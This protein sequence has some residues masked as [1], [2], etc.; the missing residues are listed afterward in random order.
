MRKTVLVTG[1]AGFIGSH[2]ADKLLAAGYKVAILDSLLTGRIGNVP[3]EASFYQSDIR[4]NNLED[5]FRLISPDY[6]LHQAAVANVRESLEEP[7]LYANVNL[8]GSLNLLQCCHK[9]A[10]KK[11]VYASTGGAVYGE[12]KNLPI[13]E[14]H[15]IQPLDPYGASKHHV[16]H[17]LHILWENYGLKFTTLR[18]SNVYGPRQD[19]NGEAGVVA[20]FSRSMLQGKNVTINGNG[21]Q[22]RDFVYVED[23]A[24]AN[25]L[26]LTNGNC[27]EYNLGTGTATSVN[28]LFEML[29]ELTEYRK[30]PLHAPPK[31]G[32]VLKTSLNSRAALDDLN[33]IAEVSLEKGLRQTLESFK[34]PH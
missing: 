16:E 31:Q 34:Y 18:Y 29:R 33:W 11:I 13:E 7:V 25:L 22:K 9:Y 23:I 32:E 24:R 28:Q 10:V 21:N 15:S 12:P 5:V 3:S 2:I 8:V 30:E 14:S 4:D 17:H 26:A 1:G 19:P 27:T 20:I 6:V